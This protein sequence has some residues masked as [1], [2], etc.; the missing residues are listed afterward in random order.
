MLHR[1]GYSPIPLYPNSIYVIVLY[2][3]YVEILGRIIDTIHHE[4]GFLSSL[5]GGI[6]THL[7]FVELSFCPPPPSFCSCPIPL[8]PNSIYMIV[9]LS[10]PFLLP[11]LPSFP[12]SLPS[13]FLA[14]PLFFLLSYGQHSIIH[15]EQ[16]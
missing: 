11:P 1:L 2:P 8:Y 9:L 14:P 12:P 10:S 13:P 15:V 5:L 3:L 7:L 6:Y 4:R 16:K